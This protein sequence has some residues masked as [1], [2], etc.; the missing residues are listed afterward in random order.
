MRGQEAVGPALRS[1]GSAVRACGRAYRRVVVDGRWYVVAAWLVA[2]VVVLLLPPAPGSSGRLLGGLLPVS[3]DALSVQE[4][5]LEAFDVPLLSGTAV[6]VHDPAGLDLLT[7]ADVALWALATSQAEL[8]G[9]VPDGPGHL[10]GAVPLPSS[11]AD[12]AVTYLYASPGTSLTR[13]TELARQYAAHFHNQASVRTYVTGVTPAQV[14]QGDYLESRLGV[15]EGA[16]VVVIAA[17]VALAFRSWVAPVAVLAVAGVGFV[18]SRRLLAA[19]AQALGFSLPHQIEPLVVALFLGVVTD[20]C[21]LLFSTFHQELATTEDPREAARRAVAR[22]AP[23]VAVAGLTVAG[24]TIALLAGDLGFFRS[25]G[26]ALSLTVV[27]GLLLSLTL[28]PAVMT[29]L[30]RRLFSLRRRQV[31]VATTPRDSERSRSRVHLLITRRGAA[32]ATAVSVAL[33]LLAALPALHLRLDQSFTAGLPEDDGARRGAQ[34]LQDSRVRGASAPTE[35]LVEGEGVARERAALA[36]FEELVRQQPEVVE[37]IGPAQSPVSERYGIVLSRDGDAARLLVVLGSD[38]LGAEAISDLRALEGRLDGLAREAGLEGVSVAV[39][40]QTA[41]ASELTALTRA[42]LQR[43]LLVA[44]GVE[45]V[46]LALYLRALVAP[47]ALLVCSALSVAA[48][49]GVTTWV[50]QDLGG[51]EGLVFYAPFATAVLL[52]ALGSDYNVFAVGAIWAEAAHRPLSQAIAVAV[53][54]S[55]RA[56]TTAGLILAATF[57]MVA[58]IP[59]AT[60]RQIAFTMTVG[61]LVDTFLVRPVLTPA[62]LTLLGR[63]AGWPGHRIRTSPE[64]PGSPSSPSA[65]EAVRG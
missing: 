61:L 1:A 22:D 24:G 40:G 43:T 7:R 35:V 62:V 63:A 46:L 29:I 57:A 17:V 10:V 49:L 55:T 11:S 13:T 50:F 60:F 19:L 34:V 25:F 58:I 36:R 38:P 52:V 32:V 47:L 56:I 14:A 9:R 28:A 16:S 44:L 37:A 42:D 18:V 2:A 54:R 31:A 15:F 33:L 12:T 45:L 39:T 48:A 23:I 3:S 8:E 20:Y 6:V 51:A 27:V 41:V 64:A 4:R 30:G 26:P 65:E 21:V 5:S 59:L 53:P